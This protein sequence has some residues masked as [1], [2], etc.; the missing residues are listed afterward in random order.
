MN[1]FGCHG[2][3][4]GGSSVAACRQMQ[5]K[6]A[7]E[8]CEASHHLALGEIL[9]AR[10]RSVCGHVTA[11]KPHDQFRHSDHLRFLLGFALHAAFDPSALSG[12]VSL[13]KTQMYEK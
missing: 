5:H 13:F 1:L 9:A 8:E 3:D 2:F 10:G 11:S 12:G 4:E 6:L 7:Q